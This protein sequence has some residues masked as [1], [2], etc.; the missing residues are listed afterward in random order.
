MQFIYLALA[1]LTSGYSGVSYKK[2][3]VCSG[4]RSTSFLR[5]YSGTYR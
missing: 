3:S 5:R 4:N 2:L 1:V